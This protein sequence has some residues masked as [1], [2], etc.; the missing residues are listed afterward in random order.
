VA[1]PACS[2]DDFCL[3]ASFAQLIH[4]GLEPGCQLVSRSPPPVMKKDD[5]WL[6]IE[7]VVMDRHHLQSMGAKRL[8][9]RIDFT[10]QH[11]DVTRNSSIIVGS[12]KC[13]PGVEAHSSIDRGS[14]FFDVEVVPAE[15]DFVHRPSMLTRMAD[16]LCNSICI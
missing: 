14:H 2:S 5:L 9:C 4:C 8:Q 3:L 13:R 10:L 11:C 1:S 6:C 15:R 16:N 7:H 12:N